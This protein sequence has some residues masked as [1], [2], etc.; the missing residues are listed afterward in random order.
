MDKSELVTG[1][2]PYWK[3]EK[4]SLVKRNVYTLEIKTRKFQIGNEK[5]PNRKLVM[6]KFKLVI[7]KC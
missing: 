6:R 3:A 7:G 5:Y 2:V 1:N 4:L